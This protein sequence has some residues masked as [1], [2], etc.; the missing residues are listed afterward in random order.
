[1][2]LGQPS[3]WSTIGLTGVM[4]PNDGWSLSPWL[5]DRLKGYR[6]RPYDLPPV[7]PVVPSPAPPPV[8]WPA[9]SMDHNAA[10]PLGYGQHAEADSAA[11]SRRFNG[12]GTLG[13]DFVTLP[14]WA[15]QGLSAAA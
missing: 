2:L 14:D 8:G 3:E 5:F 12:G 9:W 10:H 4:S 7:P 6:P 15:R 1:M 13:G 11:H